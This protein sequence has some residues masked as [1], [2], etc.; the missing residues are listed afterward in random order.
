MYLIYKEGRVAKKG[1]AI[2]FR[3]LIERNDG[4]SRAATAEKLED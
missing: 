1:G 3:G 2:P 4:E